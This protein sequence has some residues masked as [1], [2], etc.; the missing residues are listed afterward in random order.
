MMEMEQG[1]QQ[2]MERLLV[3]QEEAV[4]QIAANQ[5]EMKARQEKADAEAKTDHEQLKKTIWKPFWKD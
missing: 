4:A 3:R 2:M 5:E 1:L